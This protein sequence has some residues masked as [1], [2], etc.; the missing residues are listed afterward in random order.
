MDADESIYYA[1]ASIRMDGVR[2]SSR[3]GFVRYD[4]CWISTWS[5]R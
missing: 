4:W 2:G 1:R 5:A 3:S